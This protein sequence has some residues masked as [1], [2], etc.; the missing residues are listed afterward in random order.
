MRRHVA[1]H[2]HFL[3]HSSQTNAREREQ[4]S[5][6]LDRDRPGARL[7]LL[8]PRLPSHHIRLVGLVSSS[9]CYSAWALSQV[10]HQQIQ[11]SSDPFNFYS[12]IEKSCVCFCHVIH[13]HCASVFPNIPLRREELRHNEPDDD[14]H[15]K[16]NLPG[17]FVLRRHAATRIVD[18]FSEEIHATVGL[19]V[20]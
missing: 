3:P 4:T 12:S 17:V 11:N 8:R 1:C 5:L 7:L 9:Y 19:D 20:T 18:I 2:R 16:V 10:N 13:E 14:P 15:T 6:G